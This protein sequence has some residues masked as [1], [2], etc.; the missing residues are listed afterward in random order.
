VRVRIETQLG[1]KRVK[2]IEGIEFVS[3]ISDIGM[4][5]WREDQQFYAY[6]AGI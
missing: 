1:F 6:A 3:Y 5:G 2:W 4:G